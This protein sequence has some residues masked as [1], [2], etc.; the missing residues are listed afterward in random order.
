MRWRSGLDEE[1]AYVKYV[2]RAFGSPIYERY[3]FIHFTVLL[4]VSYVWHF[5]LLLLLPVYMV[6]FSF[7][8]NEKSFLISFGWRCESKWASWGLIDLF[9]LLVNVLLPGILQQTLTQRWLTALLREKI[10]KL[11]R[12]ISKITLLRC[13]AGK[14]I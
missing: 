8:R 13:I 9:S 4:Y 7:L 1:M 2:Y 6:F 10:N 5:N 3:L 11:L 12:G 14:M